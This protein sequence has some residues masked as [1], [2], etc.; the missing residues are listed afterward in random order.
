MLVSVLLIPR[1]RRMRS[2]TR[3]SSDRF[4]TRKLLVNLEHTGLRVVACKSTKD[5]VRGTDIVTMVTAD[6]TT[7]T[8]ITPDMLGPGMHI[9]G[10]GGDCPGKTELHPDVLRARW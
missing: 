1:T 5:A 2:S 10:V 7:A 8:I 9:N 3:E 6:K 4:A